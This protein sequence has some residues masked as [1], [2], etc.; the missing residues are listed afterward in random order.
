MKP[1]LQR[2]CEFGRRSRQLLA[3]PSRPP[4]SWQVCN[5]GHKM[6]HAALV[7]LC[8]FAGFG[9]APKHV[10]SPPMGMAGPIT[11][12]GDYTNA[13]VERVRVAIGKL[14]FPVVE[15]TIARP[16]RF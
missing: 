1:N 9:C 14:S 3:H 12:F 8:L 16:P 11:Q 2:R 5:V 13:E 15:G 7:G 6:K 4:T 10:E